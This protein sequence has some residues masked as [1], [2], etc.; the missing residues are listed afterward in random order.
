MKGKAVAVMNALDLNSN[1]LNKKLLTAQRSYMLLKSKKA[2]LNSELSTLT[3]QR[4][5]LRFAVCKKIST[6]NHNITL[7]KSVMTKEELSLALLTKQDDAK[8]T[9]RKKEEISKALSF[10]KLDF[11]F[12]FFSFCE[13]FS[14]G[15]AFTAMEIDEA[16]KLLPNLYSDILK[17]FEKE[18]KC[19]ELKVKLKETQSRMNVLSFSVISQYKKEIENIAL[20]KEKEEK[21]QTQRFLKI[22]KTVLEKANGYSL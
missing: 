12:E 1:N 5:K 17:L 14:Y 19:E 20:E 16:V 9:K 11:D 6:I 22:Q 10:L 3:E 18:K 4:E 13:N 8:T 7:A 21:A 15:Y 2:S